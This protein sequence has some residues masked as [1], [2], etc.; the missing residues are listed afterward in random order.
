LC[1]KATAGSNVSTPHSRSQAL[2]N[3]NEMVADKMPGDVDAQK[4]AVSKMDVGVG[5]GA[6]TRWR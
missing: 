3:T 2:N 5:D 6:V 1:K 4:G